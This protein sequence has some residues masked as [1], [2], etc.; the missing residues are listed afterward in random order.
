MEALKVSARSNPNS[1]AGAMAGALRRE[2]VVEVT[3]VGA[4]ALN[5]ALK[6]VAIARSHVA[7]DGIDAVCIPS[8]IDI[9]IEGEART[10]V[11]L[12]VE[13]RPPT[14]HRPPAVVDLRERGLA[15]VDRVEPI[16]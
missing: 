15:A 8:F 3:V 6:A 12:R 2:F 14:E 11:L 7:E 5:Q 16:A 9:V 4:A 13:H 1:V 10:G